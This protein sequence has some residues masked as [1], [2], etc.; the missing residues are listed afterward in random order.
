MTSPLSAGFL[1]VDKPQGWT[2]HD[3]VAKIR[4]HIGGKVGHAGTLDPMATGLL[5][6]GIG[7]ATR[8][9]RFVQGAQKE[10]IATAQFGVATDSLDADGAIISREPLPTTEEQVVAAMERFTGTILQTPP[11][12]SARR[13]EGRRLYELA[14]EGKVV[15]REARPVT[16]YRLELIDLA[17]SD[18][19]EVTFRTVCST[20]TYIRTLA[21]DLGQAVGGRAHLSALR[22]VRNGSMHVNDAVTVDEVIDA[23]RHDRLETMMLSPAHVL[24]EYPE[25]RVDDAT[26][27]RVRNGRELPDQMAPDGAGVD[28]VM[29]VGDREGNLLAMYKKD[30]QALVPEVVLH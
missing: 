21:D 7:G 6:L 28:T 23:S 3:V 26:A 18:Y 10:Y 24:G 8:L 25:L 4:K 17:P 2:S 27:F 12:V 1:L 19:P 15:E 22:R 9:L 14:R 29:R 5:V 11:M 13:V 16:I 20:G 30:G